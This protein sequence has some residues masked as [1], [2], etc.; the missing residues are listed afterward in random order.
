MGEA[1]EDQGRAALEVLVGHGLAGLV[2]E[3]ERTAD[4]GGRG[5]FL[6]P[7]HQPR[8]Q[9]QPDGEARGKGRDDHQTGD[10]SRSITNNPYS[11]DQKQAA[12]PA[13]IISKNTAVP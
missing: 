7:A 3:L 8:H 11:M 13:A 2:G 4:R 9:Q 1:E 6:Q 12:M 10:V 5:D